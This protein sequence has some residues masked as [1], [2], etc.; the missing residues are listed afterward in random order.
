MLFV[1]RG[2][3]VFQM[4][5]AMAALGLGVATVFVMKAAFDQDSYWLLPFGFIMAL[6][7]VLLFQMTLRTPTSYVAIADERTRIR[8]AGFVDTVVDNRDILGARVM[9]FPVI[10]GLGV[11]TN[12]RG[13]VALITSF[14]EAAELTLRH[15][16][17]IWVIPRL[18]PAKATRLVLSVKNPQKLVDRFSPGGGIPAATPGKPKRKSKSR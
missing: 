17:R 11:R 4:L 9:K 15:P 3:R 16:I 12:F 5:L 18:L 2:M 14:G 1:F 10:G 8:F 6:I 7:F 13:S